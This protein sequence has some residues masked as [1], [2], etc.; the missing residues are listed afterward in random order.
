M[1]VPLFLLQVVLYSSC[2]TLARALSSLPTTTTT[3]RAHFLSSAAAAFTG[4]AVLGM[5]PM[6]CNAAAQAVG[7][8]NPRYIDKNLEMKFGETPGTS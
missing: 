6:E 7:S 8:K 2:S 4:V 3:T 1:R 5:D